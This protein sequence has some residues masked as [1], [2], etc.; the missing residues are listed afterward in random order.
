LISNQKFALLISNRN[1]DDS[2]FARLRQL[3]ASIDFLKSP[4]TLALPAGFRKDR[5][6]GLS[7]FTRSQPSSGCFA[8][9]VCSS[10]QQGVGYLS[11]ARLTG[12]SRPT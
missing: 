7:E 4:M 11:V 2:R 5:Q 8:P 6:H 9:K 10:Q 12:R 1:F 3:W